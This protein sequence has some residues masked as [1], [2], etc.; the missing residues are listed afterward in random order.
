MP[1]SSDGP[2]LRVACSI[3]AVVLSCAGLAGCK[4]DP[5]S[6]PAPLDT[7]EVTIEVPPP[8]GS[9]APA[10]PER[11]L[12]PFRVWINQETPRQKKTP[13]WRTF[14]AKD[15]VVLDMAPDGNWSCLLNPARVFGQIDEDGSVTHWTTSRTLRCSND[16]W[17][18]SVES[19]VRVGFAGDGKRGEAD[20]KAVLDELP[21]IDP[22]DAGVKKLLELMTSIAED[23]KKLKAGEALFGRP[24]PGLIAE[25]FFTRGKEEYEKKEDAAAIASFSQCVSRKP[26]FAD[27]YIYRGQAYDRQSKYQ[28]AIADFTEAIKLQPQNVDYYRR[29]AMTYDY[30]TGKIRCGNC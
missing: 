4:R 23:A 9:A 3:V 6:G 28:E 18:T 30:S 13:E 12:A 26:D 16:Q 1:R 29:R 2:A 17:K 15:G 22:N 8:A 14:P 25:G 20:P 5:R 7:F 21:K 11:V 19:L 24:V 10:P 27:C